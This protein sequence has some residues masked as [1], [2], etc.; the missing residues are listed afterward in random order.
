MLRLF[1]YAQES[2]CGTAYNVDASVSDANYDAS[3]VGAS[4]PIWSVT[5]LWP[6]RCRDYAAIERGQAKRNA[7]VHP[8]LHYIAMDDTTKK[9]TAFANPDTDACLY[10]IVA[11]HHFMIAGLRFIASILSPGA[12][13]L[14]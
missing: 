14:T 8:L 2:Q 7:T 10:F 3:C 6:R 11:A 5:I 1:T 4:L 13:F 9:F 12:D